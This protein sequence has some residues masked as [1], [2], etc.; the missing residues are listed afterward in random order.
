MLECVTHQTA[1]NR[2]FSGLN[3]IPRD[4]KLRPAPGPA[5]IEWIFETESRENPNSERPKERG[6]STEKKGRGDTHAVPGNRF[7]AALVGN[8]DGVEATFQLTRLYPTVPR[9]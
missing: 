2:P 7:L 8:P 5:P 6:R 9:A 1:K 3:H 4:E